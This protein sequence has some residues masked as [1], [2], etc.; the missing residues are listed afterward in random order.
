MAHEVPPLAP[1]AF[2]ELRA[3]SGVTLAAAATGIRYKNRPDVLL[4]GLAAGTQAA[5]CLTKSKSRSAPVDWCSDAL[6]GGTARAVVI[7]AGSA[8]AFTGS[9]RGHKLEGWAGASG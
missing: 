5:G 6:A 8:N 7:N 2:R 3:I 9:A 4:A 1:A